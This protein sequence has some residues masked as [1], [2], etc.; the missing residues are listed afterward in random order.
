MPTTNF[1]GTPISDADIV[2]AMNRFDNERRATFTRWKKYAVEYK[3]KMYPPKVIL[4]IVSAYE[5]SFP[6]GEPTNRIFRELGF[7]VIDRDEDGE[8]SED[9]EEALDVTFRL[10]EDLERFLVMDLGQLESGLKL[11]SQDNRHGQQFE[12]G[13]AG[14]LD[15]LAVDKNNDLVVIELK[16]GEADRNAC[17]Q[18]QAYM[19]W[20]SDNIANGRAVR[21][22][23]VAGA[24]TE[25]LKLAAKIVPGLSL[26][27][28]SVA[29]KFSEP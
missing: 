6:G 13:P 20:V 12:A 24:F 16:A 2:N 22:V 1:R 10:E 18:I 14:R 3:S 28:Y 27:K 8:I 25:R 29:F 7:A 21:G 26:K 9:L 11:F 5:G 17:G 23:L 15:V 19:G 4:R